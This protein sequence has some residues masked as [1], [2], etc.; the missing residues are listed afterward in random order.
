[1]TKTTITHPDSSRAVIESSSG[2]GSGC[3]WIFAICLLVGACF[4]LPI[5]I[6]V[7]V[8]VL[9]AMIYAAWRQQSGRR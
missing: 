7:T 1:M 2:R 9:A 5:L 3:T 8:V 6:P 4:Q